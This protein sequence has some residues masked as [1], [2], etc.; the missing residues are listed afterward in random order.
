MI[1]KKYKKKILVTGGT[2]FLGRYFVRLLIQTGYLPILLVRPNNDRSAFERV[3]MQ[4]TVEEMANIT[5]WEGDL[6]DLQADHVP[7]EWQKIGPINAM[8]HIAGLVKFDEELQDL[9]YKVNVEGT[10][11]AIALAQGLSISR[12]FYIS[13]AYTAGKKE[14]ATETLHPL[15][16]S[17]H[18]PYEESK[19][20]A[21]HLVISKN[22]PLF[23]T[24]ILRPSIIIG[25]SKTGE[26]DTQFSI[27]GFLRGLSLFKRRVEKHL[28]FDRGQ[29]YFPLRI[30][31]DPNGLSNLVP[32]NYVAEIMLTALETECEHDI[33]HLTN[34][35]APTKQL[36]LE[37]FSELLQ[38][39]GMSMVKLLEKRSDWDEK[40][41]Q[42]I[43]VYQPYMQNDPAFLVDHTQQL[44]QKAKKKIL[45]LQKE[46]YLRIFHPVLH[47][48]ELPQPI[49]V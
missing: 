49:E 7:Q 39:R 24:T 14:R 37:V 8:F 1:D 26:A 41:A 17:F 16:N 13:T 36:L 22:N 29:A 33:Y 2:G 4:F 32:V 9:L 43:S 5:V 6:T 15:T 38:V 42:F 23:K 30:E 18:N 27:Y 40:F 25:D 44:L 31:G 45:H 12:F 46:D 47:A 19:C 48:G 21:E 35:F 28:E 20:Y 10:K 3:K 34:P 11:N